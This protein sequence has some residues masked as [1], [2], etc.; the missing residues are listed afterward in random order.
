[1]PCWGGEEEGVGEAGP[2]SERRGECSCAGRE[3][4]ANCLFPALQQLMRV[5]IDSIVPCHVYMYNHL[6]C[7][8]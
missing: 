6:Y 8:P 2:D 4:E 5:Y 1:M 7:M 3:V